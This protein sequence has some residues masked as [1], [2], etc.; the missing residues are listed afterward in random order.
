M[1]T[2]SGIEAFLA[3]CRCKSLTRAAEELFICQ[4]SLSTRLKNLEREMGTTLFLR[5]KGQREIV[6]TES[7]KEF[8]EIALAYEKV[9]N[10]IEKMRVV[11]EKKLRVSSLN[12][13]G[14]YILPESYELFMEKHPDVVLEIQDQE[15]DEACRSVL[16]GRT[17]LAFNTDNSVPERMAAMPVFSEDFTL[18]CSEKSDYP[19]RVSPHMLS[20]KNEVYIDWY[21]GFGAFHASVLGDETPQLCVNIMSQLEIFVEKP[22]NWAFVPVSVARGLVQKADIRIL[23]TDLCLPK[24]TVYC[25]HST[26]GELEE[27]YIQFLKC[28]RKI[29]LM[30]SEIICLLP[31]L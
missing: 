3:I 9:T 21:K 23:K 12:S 5:R 8:Y 31:Q 20:V 2:H 7:G 4:S 1:V 22:N 19:E 24:R 28:L 25:L 6:L 11:H 18:I 30:N 29:L 15:F 17:D 14:A 16:Q 26:E 13:L 27:H 10:R